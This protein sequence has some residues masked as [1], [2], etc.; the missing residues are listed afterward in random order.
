MLI[1][2]FFNTYIRDTKYKENVLFHRIS[3][4]VLNINI[5]KV[6]A[7]NGGEV[8]ISTRSLKH[9]YDRHVFEK[10]MINNFYLILNNF[11]EIINNPDKIY[12]NKIGK[13]GD[14]LFAKKID[15]VVCI[16]TLEII[17]YNEIDV[18]SVFTGGE[19]YLSKF[20]LLWS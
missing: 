10:G 1:D 14:F 12:K 11:F 3:I 13:R 5:Q 19:K 7:S 8:F 16:S 9:I 2:N 4:C 20:T 15:N 6:I 17:N 18:V